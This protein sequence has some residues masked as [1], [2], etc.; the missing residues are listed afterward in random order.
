MKAAQLQKFG[1]PANIKVVDV[2]DPTPSTGQILIQV[3]ASSINPIDEITVMGGIPSIEL[4]ATMGSDVTGTVV[5]V[6]DGVSGFNVGDNVYGRSDVLQGGSGAYAD[7]A[8]ADANLF[9]LAPSNISSE[10]AA[11]LPIVGISAVQ[12]LV[13]LIK[14]KSGQKIFIVGGS[15]GIGSLAIQLA[16]HLGAYVAATA[17]SSNMDAVKQLGAD[18]VY[19]YKTTDIANKLS[20]YDAILDTSNGENF[21]ELLKV[22]KKG[23]VAVSMKGKADEVTAK[24]LEI[25]TFNVSTDVNTG[26]LAKLTE[27]I[28]AGAIKPQIAKTYSLDQVT[29]AFQ[30]K[31]AGHT[32]GKIVISIN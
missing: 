12:A 16:K 3:Q 11:S 27:L 26:S 13:D 21:K 20:D 15:G 8:A 10:E 2:D 6:G 30:T 23:G 18:E 19:D 9:G 14:L 31:Q 22:L 32:P 24:Q 1:D 17:S 29:E 28:E 4:P 25:T 5:Q 7:L